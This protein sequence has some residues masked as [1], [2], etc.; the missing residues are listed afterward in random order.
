MQ[1]EVTRLAT[2]N[3][4]HNRD[5]SAVSVA[6]IAA[7]AV[8]LGQN[9]DVDGVF[10]SC[11]NLRAVEA[12]P[13]VERATGKVVTSSNHAMAW[14][15]LRLLGKKDEIEGRGKLFLLPLGSKDTSEPNVDQN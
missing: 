11:T 15:V 2:F 7:A 1:V 8:D 10:I 5:I 6:S 3:L 4:T 12:L 13:E 9:D 14:H